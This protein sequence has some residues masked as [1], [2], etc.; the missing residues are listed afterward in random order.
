MSVPPHFRA[1]A[2]KFA[3]DLHAAFASTQRAQPEDQLKGP[4]QALVQAARAQVSTKTEVH[5]EGLGGRPDIGVMVG[6][7][8]CGHVE[9]KAPGMGA[10]TKKFKG[11]DKEQW[12]KFTALPNLIYTDATEWVLYRSGVAQPAGSGQ[13]VRID[14]LIEQGPLALNEDVLRQLHDLLTDFL[15]WDYVAPTGPKALAETLAPICRLLRDDVAAAVAHPGSALKRLSAEMRDYLFPHASDEDFV[16]IYAQTLTYALLLARLN[17][18]T[19]LTTAS[20]AAALDSGH[21]LL[22]ESKRLAEA[23]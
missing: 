11:R 4:V 20:A 14:N 3:T 23:S 19:T 1:A 13:V 18:E 2:Q 15:T 10:L 7:L 16:D 17:G 21:G 6:K 8:L 12:Q 22:A 5:V 9:L